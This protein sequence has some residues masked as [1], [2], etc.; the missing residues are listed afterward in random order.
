[1]TALIKP[2]A[3]LTADIVSKMSDA[4][5]ETACELNLQAGAIH[6]VSVAICALELER[7]GRPIPSFG[8][9]ARWFPA[10]AAGTLDP[11]IVLKYASRPT[12]L[13]RLQSVPLAEQRILAANSKVKLA[14]L[15]GTMEIP[16]ERLSDSQIRQVISDSGIR[17]PTEQVG[18]L[19]SQKVKTI[20]KAT[21]E[22]R[23]A[24]VSI[25]DGK[26]RIGSYKIPVGQL[27]EAL[28]KQA[29]PDKV[30]PDTRAIPDDLGGNEYLV[31]RVRMTNEEHNALLKVSR[32]SGSSPHHLIR[33]ACRAYGLFN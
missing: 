33:M 24:T 1:M 6:F 4:E 23:K 30:I 9:M 5:L 11:A 12:I 26:A 15:E 27:V 2:E 13:M 20:E 25:A 18:Y 8:G 29:G 17:S 32:E 22:E 31:E 28:A 14:T 16:L 19:Q 10:V 3:A 21:R 7:R